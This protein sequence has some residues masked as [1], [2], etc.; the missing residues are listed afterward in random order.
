MLENCKFC[1]LEESVLRENNGFTCADN[2]ITVFFTKEYAD[3]AYQLLGKSYC[4]IEQEKKQIVCAFTVAN[5]SIRADLLP[6][7][8]RNKLNR[9]I[10]N[11]KR[12]SQYPA[13]LIGQLA[14]GIKYKGL[15]I[16]NELLDF[17]KSWFID[18]L[19][20]TGCRY[21]VVDALN[22]PKILDFYQRNGFN[23]LFL[24]EDEERKFL[25]IIRQKNNVVYDILPLNTRLMYF[26]LILLR[27]Q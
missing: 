19:N 13:V 3:Y 1:E 25:H 9:Q 10:P 14:V 27:A 17:I 15:H 2:N 6:N 20:K 4:F 8:R 21:I 26:D 12:R 22:N 11:E 7:S 23:F 24:T 16:G 5:S 18:P